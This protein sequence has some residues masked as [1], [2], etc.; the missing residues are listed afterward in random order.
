[1]CVYTGKAVVKAP[2]GGGNLPALSLLIDVRQKIDIGSAGNVAMYSSLTRVLSARW[3]VK[4]AG[5]FVEQKRSLM[6]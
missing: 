3:C 4:R 2:A 5:V 6:F 1:M